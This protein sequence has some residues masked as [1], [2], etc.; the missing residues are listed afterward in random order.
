[1]R[2]RSVAGT[3]PS[4]R[5]LQILKQFQATIIWTTPSYAWYLGETAVKE[6]IDPRKDL[7][8]KRIFVAG[9]PGGSIPETRE[10]IP[11]YFLQEFEC[12]LSVIWRPFNKIVE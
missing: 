5:L 4:E 3:V 12:H 7:A 2:D 8:V 10:R 11:V 1:M 6:G 9:E